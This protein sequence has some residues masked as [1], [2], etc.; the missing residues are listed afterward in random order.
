[1]QQ[2]RRTL[3]LLAL[4]ALLAGAL[5]ARV[6]WGAGNFVVTNTNPSG[7]GSLADAIAQANAASGGTITFNI[8]SAPQPGGYWTI[9]VS[10]GV[11]PELTSGSISIDGRSQPGGRTDGGP[12]IEIRGASIFGS[13][14]TLR[15]AN[16]TIT[17]F[18]INNFTRGVSCFAGAIGSCGAGVTIR[19]AAATGNQ[20]YGNYIGTDYTGLVAIPN[21]QAGVAIVSG[22]NN[23][24]VGRVGSGNVIAGNGNSSDRP[25]VLIGNTDPD[26]ALN[27]S[28]NVIAGNFIG[29]GAD[30][31]TALPGASH[32]VLIAANSLSNTIGPG[33]YISG[34]GNGSGSGLIASYGILIAGAFEGNTV[35]SNRVVGNYIGLDVDGNAKPNRNGGVRVIY[36]ENAA[37]A[38]NDII[39]GP[40][41]ADRN[42]IAGNNQYGITIDTPCHATPPVAVVV[43]NNVVGLNAAG[44]IRANTSGGIL[45]SDS[46]DSNTV[47]GNLG[48]CNNQIGPNNVISGNGG[49]G[50]LI[51]GNNTANPT[52]ANIVRG[53][54]IGTG[55]SGA[56]VLANSANGIRIAAN[57][58]GNL[59]GGSS[60]ANAADRNTISGNGA[61]GVLIES[62]PN[63]RVQGNIITAHA[64][65]NGSGVVI[66][67]AG[68]TGNQVLANTIG[69]VAGGN[70]VGVRITGGANNNTIGAGNDIAFN[71]RYGIE[72]T[73]SG[74]NN[75]LVSQS[76]VHDNGNVGPGLFDGISIST[77]TGNRISQTTT[78][79]NG[80][81]TG[82]GINLN[83]GAAAGNN[84]IAAPTLALGAGTLVGTSTCGAGCTVEIFTSDAPEPSEGNLYI[85]SATTDAG[86]AFSAALP[87]AG[88]KPYLIATITSPAGNTSE[89]SNT[90]GPVASCVP[91]APGILLSKD[92]ADVTN[93]D[94]GTTYT[95][96]H[97]LTNSGTAQGTYNISFSSSQGWGTLVPSTASY[98]LAAGQSVVI[99]VRVVVPVGAQAGASDTSTISAVLVGGGSASQT[100]V[101]TVRQRFD[102]SFTPPALSSPAPVAA[103]SSTTYN[104][105]ITNLGNG[106]DTFAFTFSN[107]PASP[108]VSVSVSAP[109]CVNVAPGNSCSVAVTVTAPANPPASVI[110]TITATSKDGVTKRSVVDTTQFKQVAV[111]VIAPASVSGSGKPGTSVQLVHTLS[112]AGQIA[113]TFTVQ[114]PALGDGWTASVAQPAPNTFAPGATRKFTVTVNIPAYS[115]ANPATYAGYVKTV[116]VNVPASGENPAAVPASDQVTVLLAPA[117]TITPPTNS[118]FAAPNQ[119]V[120]F[121]HTLNNTGNGD[122]TF[123][124]SAQPPAAPPGWAVA[125]VDPT[126]GQVITSLALARGASR[127]F[128]VRVTVPAAAVDAQSYDV[129]VRATA[130]S[131]AAVQASATETI[132]IRAGAV[133][134]LNG[135]LSGSI[136][137]GVTLPLNHTI[138]NVGNAVGSFDI[139]FEG[140]PAGWTAS[141]TPNPTAPLAPGAPAVALLVQ[142]T[143]AANALAGVYRVTVRATAQDANQATTSVVDTITVRQRAEL[144][145]EPNHDTLE[146]PGTVVTYTHT[147]T[148]AGNFTDTI[149]LSISGTR[150]WAVNVLP[151]S[152][153]L[154]PQTTAKVTVTVSVPPGIVAGLAN[155]ATITAASSLPGVT[156]QATDITTVAA[157]PGLTLSPPLFVNAGEATKPVTFTYTLFN[158]GSVTQDYTLTAALDPGLTGWSATVLSPTVEALAP[159]Q[160]AQ[161]RLVVIAPENTPNGTIGNTTLTARSSVA[162]NPTAQAVA[163]LIVGPAYDVVIAPPRASGVLP[164]QVYNY[165]HTVTNT[166]LFTDTYLLSTVSLLGWTTSIV[167]ASVSL[168]PGATAQVTV[169]VVVPT[170]AQADVVEITRAYARS[171]TQPKV[172]P[173]VED[174]STVLQVAGVE[175]SPRFSSYVEAGTTVTFLHQVTNIGNGVDSFTIS[176]SSS[177]G[178][179]VTIDQTQTPALGAGVPFPVTLRATVPA[180]TPNDQVNEIV[181]RAT[182]NFDGAVSSQVTDTLGSPRT[183]VNVIIVPDASY[184]QHLPLV[185]R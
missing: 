52:R 69:A 21:A 167:P 105:T 3:T 164:G 119:V 79:N 150:P 152:I 173:Y 94:A 81:T 39:G 6:A 66:Q 137:P 153:A 32:G 4:L 91:A 95:Y 53:N 160:T 17:G 59:V 174:T 166:G 16:N 106:P 85:G 114:V 158:S 41:A 36:D 115:A 68:S 145:L 129:T 171:A 93:A 80:S 124:L 103:G 183:P 144:L 10:S 156:A 141:T 99:Q 184:K 27:L 75:N 130:R 179:P 73:G 51:Q 30:G 154:A 29:L 62:S 35:E 84:G 180:G 163:R 18:I 5:P 43:Q 126:T 92:T 172:N 148:N 107:N 50:V 13:G 97:T 178:W 48:T 49:D 110:S 65:A 26:D 40:N 33:N 63:N 88:C 168:A 96:N 67:N 83:I 8:A 56:G 112:N 46:P 127:A 22:A 131:D 185:A 77:G 45:L 165:S 162:P 86:G 122:E 111:P 23:N 136:D 135:P 125:F 146:N 147:L 100:D 121:S 1:V 90:V 182:S 20:V 120:E 116:P 64:S 143:P 139:T 71:R 19:T 133:P 15:S 142:I 70:A 24:T 140:L 44:A 118:A 157:V 34:N 57:T 181:L 76:A 123:D 82:K 14:F 11:L 2:A 113:G 128:I 155:T 159:G 101:T 58:S 176:V 74:T 28:G 169:T 47:A 55:L 89:F 117:A 37:V 78:S 7:A 87:I 61:F 109:G 149:S 31:R 138:Q 72:I 12:K 132:T 108:A 151:K 60:T 104:H 170:S 177:L 54:L 134:L 25:Q 9:D 98:T 38:S 102:F 42:F 161:V 175:V